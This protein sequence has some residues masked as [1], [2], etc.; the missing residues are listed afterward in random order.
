MALRARSRPTLLLAVAALLV[1]AAAGTSPAGAAKRSPSPTV[2]S[3]TPKTA[4]VGESLI[5]R[6]RHFRAGVDRNTV[7]FKRSGARAVFVKAEKGTTKLLKVTL[8]ARLEKVLA[9]QN[10]TPVG[11]KLRLR[12]LAGKLGKR[13]TS[14]GDSPTINPQRPPAPPTP[15]PADPAADCDADGTPNAS[16]P[17]DDGDLLDDATEAR[18]KLDGCKADTDGDGAGD[19]YEYASA[20]DLNDDEYQNPNAFLPYPAKRPYPNPLDGTDAGVDHDGDSLDLL[21]E[22][23]LWRLTGQ[24]ALD[25]LTYSAGEQYSLSA[26]NGAGRRVPTQSATGYAKQADFLAWASGGGYA[27]VAL[28]DPGTSFGDDGADWWAP[29]S[30]Y[31][32]RDIDRSG[33]VDGDEVQYYDRNNGWLDDSERDEDA[34]GLSNWAETRGCMV[35]SYWNGLY[36]EET[37]YPL[38]YGGVDAPGTDP[39]DADSDGDGVRDGADDIDNDDVPN[40]VECS[41][42]AGVPA[43]WPGPAFPAQA[44]VNPFNPCLPHRRSRTCSLYVTIGSEWAPFNPDD[45]F[46][47]KN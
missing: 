20:R 39:A 27:S 4:Y 9:V 10:G 26:R 35:R 29:R 34:D 40:L 5:V 42:S 36:D 32:V 2:T 13:F 12:V 8:P 43:G 45:V 22:S 28:A 38:A 18:L 41:R 47:I 33:A 6:G 31:D 11:T 24:R 23:R 44:M 1:P 21:D 30:V 37:P 14:L 25:G 19:G 46:S 15:P 16:D 3:V 17:D 7:V